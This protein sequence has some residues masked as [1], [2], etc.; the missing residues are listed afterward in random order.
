MNN[1]V[2]SK[3]GDNAW[4]TLMLSDEI[5][6]LTRLH[7][8]ILKWVE[9][10]EMDSQGFRQEV[11]RRRTPQ[12]DD[13]YDPISNEASNRLATVRV[14]FANLG[15]TIAACAE[16]FIIRICNVRS[17]TCVKGHFGSTCDSLGKSLGVEISQLP[18]YAGNQRAR[19]L[20]NC[21]KHTEGRTDDRFAGKYGGAVGE[22][23]QY[24]KEDWP[25]MIAETNGLLSEIIAK[26]AS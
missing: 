24:E 3:Y 1:P 9:V 26:L 5:G 10:A 7:K 25:S 18:G 2:Q 17:V 22:D 13:E 8:A 16:N 23:I 15:V 19:L 4:F 11:E 20:G 6:N 12:W 21:F 14:M